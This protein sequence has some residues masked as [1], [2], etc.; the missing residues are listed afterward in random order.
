MAE[1]YDDPYDNLGWRDKIDRGLTANQQ[2]ELRQ[3]IRKH[4]A[5]EINGY[6]FN[7]FAKGIV[8]GIE[9]GQAFAKRWGNSKGGRSY[10]R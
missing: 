1:W 2:N 8:P 10:P 6:D 9:R 3:D 4:I 7:Y 5:R